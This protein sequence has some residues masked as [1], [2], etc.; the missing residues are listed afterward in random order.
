MQ[1]ERTLNKVSKTSSMTSLLHEAMTKDVLL[2][3][4]RLNIEALKLSN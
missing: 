4:N 1:V 3:F 2:K